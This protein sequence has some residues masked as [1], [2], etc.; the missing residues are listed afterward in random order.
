[1]VM[2]A[3]YPVFVEL[4]GTLVAENLLIVLELAAV[5]TMLRARRAEH[6]Y[7]WIVATGLLTG[8]ATL[9]H[10]NAIVFVIPFAFAAWGVAGRQPDRTR[11]PGRT[12]ATQ[13]AGLM[14]GPSRSSRPWASPRMI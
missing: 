6:P 9:T 11:G 8:V 7:P 2:A 14:A 1:M 12:P 3:F 4:T 10:E 13:T 5:W